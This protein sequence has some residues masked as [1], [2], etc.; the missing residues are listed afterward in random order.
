MGSIAHKLNLPPHRRIHPIFH[1]SLLK[2]AGQ[3][4]TVVQALPS[5]L[6]EELFLDVSLEA[7]LETRTNDQGVMEVLINWQQL[8]AIK[9]SWEIAIAI[10]KEF[11]Q[12]PQ[13]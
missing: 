8:P 11:P 12:F 13:G 6:T 3:P 5:I 4:T 10:S 2:R 1:V 7:L 9:N